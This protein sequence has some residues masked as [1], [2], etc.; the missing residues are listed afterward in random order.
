MLS[1][2]CRALVPMMACAHIVVLIWV[3]VPEITACRNMQIPTAT[4]MLD[5][6]VAQARSS[7]GV[8]FYAACFIDVISMA[9]ITLVSSPLAGKHDIRGYSR[10]V[11]ALMIASTISLRAR[12]MFCTPNDPECCESLQCPLDTNIV[13]LPGCSADTYAA[14]QIDW[15][16][17]QNWCPMPKWYDSHAAKVCSGLANTPDVASCNLYGC[18]PL[19]P[20]QYYGARV[21]MWNSLLFAVVSLV[22]YR[23]LAER[24]I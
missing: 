6:A 4:R 1:K 23:T 7:R 17:R 11:P 14:F 21:I 16:E 12:Y 5:L 9:Y 19:V 13:T 20:L 8:W 10:W 24:T 15:N 18:S 22:P 3:Y 2:S